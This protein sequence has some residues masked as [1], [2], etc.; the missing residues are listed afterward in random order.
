MDLRLVLFSAYSGDLVEQLGK[1][2]GAPYVSET[3]M[4][5][6]NI[7]HLHLQ[8]TRDAVALMS[9]EEFTQQGR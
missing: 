8:P 6:S 5:D 1:E 9:E 3:A 4:E 2:A 7:L